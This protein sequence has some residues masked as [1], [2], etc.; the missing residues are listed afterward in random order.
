MCYGDEVF[1]GYVVGVNWCC[2]NGLGCCCKVFD[3]V[4]FIVKKC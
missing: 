3:W 4:L 2:L 1:F